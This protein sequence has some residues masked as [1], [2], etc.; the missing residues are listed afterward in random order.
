MSA[1]IPKVFSQQKDGYRD[2]QVSL[3]GLSSKKKRLS[4]TLIDLNL[5]NMIKYDSAADEQTDGL[6]S[7]QKNNHN[8]LSHSFLPKAQVC[9]FTASYFYPSYSQFILIE[10]R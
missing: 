9:L 5:D 3:Q 6:L 10:V 8:I 4:L 2:V 1:A 7:V